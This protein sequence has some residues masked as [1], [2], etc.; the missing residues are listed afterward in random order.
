[1]C[2]DCHRDGYKGLN[3]HGKNTIKKDK[4]HICKVPTGDWHM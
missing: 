1:M 2:G 4:R 3:G